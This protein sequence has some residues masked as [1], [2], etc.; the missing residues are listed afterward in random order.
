MSRVSDKPYFVY[1]LW[2]VS[3]SCFYIG[4]SEDPATR[5]EQHN[6]GNFKSWTKRYRP[7]ALV[8]SEP[9]PDYKSAR[10]REIELK[11]QKSGKGFFAKTGLDPQ[12]FGH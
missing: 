2:S 8:F 4:I 6:S 9:H 7:W 10:K 12:R 1:V 5:E 3:G 11:A